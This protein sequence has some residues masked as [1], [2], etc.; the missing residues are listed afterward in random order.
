MQTSVGAADARSGGV[1]AGL[2]ECECR[3]D[4]AGIAR[5]A[6]AIDVAPCVGSASDGGRDGWDCDDHYGRFNG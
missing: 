6:G 2:G 4:D 1:M 5:M 3:V